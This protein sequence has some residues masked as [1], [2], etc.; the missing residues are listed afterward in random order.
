[1]DLSSMIQKYEKSKLLTREM[2][3]AFIKEVTVFDS[4][5]IEIKW[6]FSSLPICTEKIDV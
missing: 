3:E 4:Q 1:M 6:N 2:V 5:H